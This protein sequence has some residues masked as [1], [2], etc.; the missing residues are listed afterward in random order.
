MQQDIISIDLKLPKKWE[1]LTDKQLRYVFALLSQG[2]TATE[3]K[4]YCLWRWAGLKVLHRYGNNGWACRHDRKCCRWF[5][6]KYY[7]S[8]MRIKEFYGDNVGRSFT[9]H[10]ERFRAKCK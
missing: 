8:V 5:S 10:F 3:V 6:R 7:A 4:A 9:G 1:D 2:F